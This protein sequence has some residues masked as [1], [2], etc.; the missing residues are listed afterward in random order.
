MSIWKY[1]PF[2]IQTSFISLLLQTTFRGHLWPLALNLIGSSSPQLSHLINVIV[3]FLKH[4]SSFWGPPSPTAYTHTLLVHPLFSWVLSLHLT[5]RAASSLFLGCPQLFLIT[6]LDFEK[7]PGMVSGFFGN[8]SLKPCVE[9]NSEA[10]CSISYV[11]HGE[12]TWQWQPELR[13]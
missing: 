8:G 13:H 2:S 10:L 11:C 12:L 9:Q 3:S 7:K 5:T 6:S 1:F 4:S